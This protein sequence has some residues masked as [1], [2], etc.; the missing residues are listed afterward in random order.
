MYPLQSYGQQSPMQPGTY[1]P[2]SNV[3]MPQFAGQPTQ[4]RTAVQPYHNYAP[5]QAAFPSPDRRRVNNH[6]SLVGFDPLLS[7]ATKTVTPSK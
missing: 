4:A 7:G 2:S 1:H 6:R 5:N 3:I